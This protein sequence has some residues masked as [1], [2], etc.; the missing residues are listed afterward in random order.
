MSAPL[1][2]SVAEAA[3]FLELTEHL[4]RARVADGT[5]RVVGRKGV[6]RGRAYMIDGND[7]RAL[8]RRRQLG[9]LGRRQR[10]VLV[11]GDL[12]DV[13]VAL[14]ASGL[15]PERASGILDAL[16]RHD[17]DGAPIIVA[18][19]K[20]VNDELAILEP[21]LGQIHLGIVTRSQT[22]VPWRVEL[23]AEILDP[24]EPRRLVQWAWNALDQRTDAGR[25]K[26]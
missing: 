3:R 10:L 4:V 13:P 14:R 22:A 18:S 2:Y 8:A 21:L 15:Y 23:G 20:A 24:W 17:V 1:T 5:L 6:G 9:E 26:L 19:P 7:V 11:V 25:L 16:S 12:T